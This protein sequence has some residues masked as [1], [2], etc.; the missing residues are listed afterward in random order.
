MADLN[1]VRN[2]QPQLVRV[3]DDAQAE[4]VRVISEGPPGPPGPAGS[5]TMA[6]MNDVDISAV[7]N[8]STLI[9]DATQQKWIGNTETTVEEILNGGNY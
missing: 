3:R 1:I 4:L 5:T 9:Y 8:R 6:G 2:G 7:A